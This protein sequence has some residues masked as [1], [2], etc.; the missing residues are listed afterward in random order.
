MF[1]KIKKTF[2]V[3]FTFTISLCCQGCNDKDKYNDFFSINGWKGIEIYSHLIN[4]IDYV[5]TFM[6][7]TNILKS[8]DMINSA[9][10][11]DFNKARNVVQYYKKEKNNI[12]MRLFILPF[13]CV[14]E[15]L[16]NNSPELYFKEKNLLAKLYN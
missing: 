15:D 4:E 2:I 11:V 5:F 3:I 8:P 16:R 13:P 12:S 6:D 14:Y 1:S 7:G 10:Y 9:Y